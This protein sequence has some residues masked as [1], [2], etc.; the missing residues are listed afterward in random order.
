MLALPQF[1]GKALVYRLRQKH[2][3]GQQLP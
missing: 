3:I 2:S 1:A